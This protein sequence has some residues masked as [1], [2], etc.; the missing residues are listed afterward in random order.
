[1]RRKKRKE[2]L[3]TFQQKH[4]Q[5]EYVKIDTPVN[6][7]PLVIILFFFFIKIKHYFLFCC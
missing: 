3:K 4:A 2:N 5:C 7:T 6:E 1:M